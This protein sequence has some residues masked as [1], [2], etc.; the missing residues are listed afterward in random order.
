MHHY[1]A[2]NLRNLMDAMQKLFLPFEKSKAFNYHCDDITTQKNTLPL[3]C[4]YL[5]LAVISPKM[6][7]QKNNVEYG[8]V[9]IKQHIVSF[10]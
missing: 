6:K 2:L 7:R 5:S 4:N 3:F 9:K 10:V 8:K 1:R